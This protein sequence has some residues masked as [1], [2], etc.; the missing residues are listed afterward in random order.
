MSAPFPLPLAPLPPPLPP[1]HEQLRAMVVKN[2]QILE[3]SVSE[4]L[5]PQIDRWL[6]GSGLG[7]TRDA[8]RGMAVACPEVGV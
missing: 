3:A 6:E 1:L 8:L 7:L 5:A 2:P 4:R